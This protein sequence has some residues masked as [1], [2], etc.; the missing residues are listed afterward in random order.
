VVA[1]PAGPETVA[2]FV[3][4]LAKAAKPATIDARLAAI[5]AAHRAAGHDS[6]TKEEAVRLV[7]RGVRRTLGTAQRQ[8]RPVTVPDLRPFARWTAMATS[9]RRVSAA[10]R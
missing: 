9:A 7:R 6:P 8:V 10:M 1:L 4:E 3:A 2:C 5:S